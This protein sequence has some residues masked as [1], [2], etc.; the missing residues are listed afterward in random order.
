M[1]T[2]A[3]LAEIRALLDDEHRTHDQLEDALQE[4]LDDRAALLSAEARFA[5]RWN[6]GSE[7]ATWDYAEAQTQARAALARG[8][9]NVGVACYRLEQVD[10][11]RATEF[12]HEEPR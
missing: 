7:P 2:P 11:V 1:L 6:G 8:H 5:V 9:H 3:R 12:V 4:L 10:W